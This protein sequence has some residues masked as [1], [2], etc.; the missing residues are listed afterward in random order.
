MDLQSAVALTTIPGISRPR[1]AVAFK[2]LREH[3]RDRAV[4]RRRHRG[5]LPI[6]RRRRRAAARRRAREAAAE[7]LECGRAALASRSSRS[8]TSAIRRCCA[9]LP[10]RRRSSG[11]RGRV[12]VLTRP[13]VAIVGSRAATPYALRRRRAAGRRARRRRSLVVS[14]GWRAAPT[15]RRTAAASAPAAPPWRSSDADPTSSIRRSTASWPQVSAET[16][17]LVSELG[18]GGAA[19][20]GA[21]SA[22]ESADQWDLAGRCGRRSIGTERFAH[23]GPIRARAGS[24]RHGG[25]RQRAWRPEPRLACAV[26]GRRKGRRDCGRYLGGARLGCAECLRPQ[27]RPSISDNSLKTGRVTGTDWRPARLRARRTVVLRW[28]CRVPDCWPG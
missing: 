1:A 2:D 13:A 14:A 7:L 9:R 21:L 27:A 3:S 15:G 18:P 17:A 11:S 4:P 8:R 28:D 5:M 20:S 26:E 19:A 10:I 23:Y 6:G 24:R 12:D 25:A 16:G 22:A